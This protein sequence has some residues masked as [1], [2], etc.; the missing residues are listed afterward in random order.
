VRSADLPVEAYRLPL[1][2]EQAMSDVARL[3]DLE[4]RIQELSSDERLWLIERVVHGLGA[5]AGTDRGATDR[6]LSAMAANPEIQQELRQIDREFAG[7]EA[8]GLE[9]G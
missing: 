8:D 3:E 1:H 7:T 2:E 5:G 9:G 6:E 4:R